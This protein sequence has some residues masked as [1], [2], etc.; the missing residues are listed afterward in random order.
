MSETHEAVL[1]LFPAL[2]SPTSTESCPLGFARLS[3]YMSANIVPNK[4]G[5]IPSLETELNQRKSQTAYYL[6]REDGYSSM[7]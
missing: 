2:V 5:K 4:K 6:V 3:M 7:I 1:N